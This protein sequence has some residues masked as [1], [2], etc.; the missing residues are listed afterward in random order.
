MSILRIKQ[1][2]DNLI[3]KIENLSVSIEGLLNENFINNH[4]DKKDIEKMRFNLRILINNFESL[5]KRFSKNKVSMVGE[6]FDKI[7]L[8]MK[9]LEKNLI[10][11]GDKVFYYK[12]KIKQL[13]KIYI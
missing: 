6:E 10:P 8:E 13:E 5:Q 3:Q 9:E 1:C 2:I 7:H 4:H 12:N 11:L